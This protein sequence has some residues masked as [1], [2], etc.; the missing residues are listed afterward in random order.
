MRLPSMLASVVLSCAAAGQ[1]LAQAPVVTTLDSAGEVGRYSDVALR[2]DRRGFVAYSDETNARLKVA[3]CQDV[4][5]TSALIGIVDPGGPFDSIAVAIG[6]SGRPIVAYRQRTIRSIKVAHCADVDCTAADIVT[7]E[8]DGV[9]SA[10]ADLVIGADG[11]PV[12]AYADGSATADVIKVAHCEDAGCLTRTVTEYPDVVSGSSPALALGADGRVVFASKHAVD[13][14]V[15]HCSNAACTAATFTRLN[16]TSSPSFVLAY[17][18]PSLELGGD[19]RIA[20]VFV[21]SEQGFPFPPPAVFLELRRCADVACTGLGPNTLPLAFGGT[22]PLIGMAPG[23]RPVIA[24]YGGE[25]AGGLRLTVRRCTTPACPLSS[26]VTWVDAE[27]NG[28]FHHSLALSPLGDALLSYDGVNQDLKVAWLGSPAEIAIGN[29]TIQEGQAGQTL[30]ALPV[31]L[32]GTSA[33]T[34]DFTTADG[35]ATAGVDYLAVSGT[36]TLT[37]GAPLQMVTVPVLGDLLPEPNETFRVLLAN[38]QGAPI[39]DGEGI[40]TIDDDEPHVSISD[41]TVVEGDAGSTSALFV[42]SQEAPG[43]P[44]QVDFATEG[45]TATSNV[46]FLASAGT[47]S[48]AAGQSSQVVAV[49]VVGDLDIEPHETFRVVLSNPQGA[50]LDDAVGMGTITNDDGPRLTIGDGS[51]VEGDTGTVALLLAVTLDVPSASPVTVQY[52]TSGITAVQGEDFLAASGVLSFAP[53]QTTRNVTVSVVGDQLF[54]GNETFRVLLSNPVGALLLDPEGIGTIVDDD[55]KPVPEFGELRHGAMYDGDLGGGADPFALLQAPY[56]SYEVVVDGV[57]GNAVPIFLSRL[58]AG[59]SV[60]QVGTSVG[61]GTAL[62]LRWRVP[63]AVPIADQTVRVSGTCGGCSA[64]DA[65]R[66]RAYETTLRAARFN[67]GGGQTTVLLLQNASDAPIALAVHFWGPDGTLVAT[68]EPAAPLPPHGVL[69]LD[70]STVAPGA[71]G[72]LTVAHDA[73]YGRLVG[74]SVAIEPSTG[75]AFDTPLEPRPR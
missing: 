26:P 57:S 4:A 75:F 27:F 30:A 13:L 59:G 61:T 69:V 28:T 9:F 35:T 31:T 42:V 15:G 17:S 20:L 16:G 37:P 14:R 70:T 48:F 67:N 58:D 71:S 3:S 7:L 6:A 41:V 50:I 44:F 49:P 46:D 68:H 5:C 43:G 63:G 40:G 12:V 29:A 73:P 47:L 62:S 60:V 39:V 8:P 22:L 54:E 38:A 45:V 52:A 53:G 55:T 2:A 11:L 51:V 66:V 74:K 24:Q 36:L 25:G 32:G 10:G 72:S 64:E 18:S 34:V 65:Y 19:G 23:D 1:A 21:R 33:A 56:A